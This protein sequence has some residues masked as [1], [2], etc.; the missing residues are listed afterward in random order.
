MKQQE[1]KTLASRVLEW[2][3]DECDVFMAWSGSG[4]CDC[5]YKEALTKLTDAALGRTNA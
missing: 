3:T 2:H 1:I 5:G 4:T